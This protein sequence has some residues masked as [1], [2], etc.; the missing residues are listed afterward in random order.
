MLLVKRIIVIMR[1]K[2]YRKVSLNL[3]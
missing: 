3:S 1:A 2:N